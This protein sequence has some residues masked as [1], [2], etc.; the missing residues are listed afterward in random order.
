MQAQGLRAQQDFAPRLP[1]IF[2]TRVEHWWCPGWGFQV[3][4]GTCTHDVFVIIQIRAPCPMV[5]TALLLVGPCHAVSE[6][7]QMMWLIGLSFLFVVALV[8]ACDWILWK[9]VCACLDS[10]I[11]HVQSSGHKNLIVPTHQPPCESYSNPIINAF[12]LNAFASMR[13]PL[14]KYLCAH[15]CLHLGMN[16]TWNL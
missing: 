11:V 2:Q 15:L 16:P 12:V 7:C 1:P 5:H 8:V 10:S 13:C 6:G 14:C 9:L 3:C 4:R